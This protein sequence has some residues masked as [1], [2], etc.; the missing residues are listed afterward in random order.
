[1][2][3][4][5]WGQWWD[6]AFKRCVCICPRVR[7]FLF[8]HTPF[9]CAL[10]KRCHSPCISPFSIPVIGKMVYN[11]TIQ[12][13]CQFSR[14]SLMRYTTQ[15]SHLGNCLNW[16]SFALMFVPFVLLI[17]ADG[18]K[19]DWLVSFT[20]HRKSSWYT[21]TSWGGV[22]CTT[23]MTIL[24]TF[25]PFG[26]KWYVY[27]HNSMAVIIILADYSHGCENYIL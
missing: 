26:H 17:E 3:R 24:K 18:D 16:L 20:K 5:P 27:M 10:F 2:W 14:M 11:Y 22:K 21:N 19:I 23:F 1:M 13:S 8:S 7:S 25:S 12:N 15:A 9:P 6:Y 4:W